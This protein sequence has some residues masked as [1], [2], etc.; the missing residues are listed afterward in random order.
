MANKHDV[1]R[2]LDQGLTPNQ[3]AERLGCRP[4]YV[5][6]TRRRATAEGKALMCLW[7][8]Q[9]WAND[10]EFRAKRLARQRQRRVEQRQQRMQL[11]HA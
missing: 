3:I 8:R 11:E 5:R 4:E 9:R 1:L 10:P 2:L 7:Y 6:A